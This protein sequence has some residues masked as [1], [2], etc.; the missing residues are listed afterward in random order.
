MIRALKSPHMPPPRRHFRRS[1]CYWD[2]DLSLYFTFITQLKNMYVLFSMCTQ[3][4]H[5]AKLPNFSIIFK[6]VSQWQWPQTNSLYVQILLKIQSSIYFPF[7]FNNSFPSMSKFIDRSS[8]LFDYVLMTWSTWGIGLW[9]HFGSRF[10]AHVKWFGYFGFD[11]I[12]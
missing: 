5:S 3:L 7:C 6:K 8:N 12:E 4:W 9:N 11:W 1:Y 2:I 10:L